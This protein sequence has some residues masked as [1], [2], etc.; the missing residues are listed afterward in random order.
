MPPLA[1]TVT[2]MDVADATVRRQMPVTPP[3]P[4]PPGAVRLAWITCVQEPPCESEIAR[5]TATDDDAPPVARTT[6][7]SPTAGVKL[8]VVAVELVDDA[9]A[10]AEVTV[11]ATGQAATVDTVT[12]APD[13]LTL[14]PL[15]T[16]RLAVRAKLPRKVPPLE[17][18]K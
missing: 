9:T 2:V 11:M 10:A 14:S 7:S 12:V 16:A 17:A 13:M 6:R 15:T 1:V 8:P 5:V 18:E 4:S 3:P